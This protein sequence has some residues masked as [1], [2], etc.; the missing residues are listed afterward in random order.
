LTKNIKNNHHKLLL[1]LLVN[2]AVLG[3]GSLKFPL[4]KVIRGG[5]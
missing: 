1:T 2:S 3:Y 5:C 4:Y